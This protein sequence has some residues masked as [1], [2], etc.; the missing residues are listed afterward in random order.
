M[1]VERASQCTVCA[2]GLNE[3]KAIFPFWNADYQRRAAPILSVISRGLP[4]RKQRT[5]RRNSKSGNPLETRRDLMIFQRNMLTCTYYATQLAHTMRIPT[6]R[7]SC[8]RLSRRI[9]AQH[10]A[11]S[12]HK[13]G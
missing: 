5:N 6:L 4:S 12:T 7:S 1:P 8:L 13:G 9:L 3:L 2:S 10:C 11:T